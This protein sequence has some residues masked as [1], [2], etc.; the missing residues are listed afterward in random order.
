MIFDNIMTM[1]YQTCGGFI[2]LLPGGTSAPSWV[3]TSFGYMYALDELLPINKTAA[4]L[5]TV[6]GIELSLLT[7]ALMSKM[8]SRR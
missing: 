5:R 8:W 4:F 3:S 7:Y 6:A 1:I 2:D